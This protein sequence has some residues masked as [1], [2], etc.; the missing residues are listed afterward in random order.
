MSDL[1]PLHS[2][3][4]TRSPVYYGWIILF[5]GTLGTVMTT[6]GQTIG[7]SAFVDRIVEDLALS[8]SQV[9]LAYAVGTLG[10]SLLLPA[11]GRTIDRV[12]PRQAMTAI[13]AL[14]TLA[15]VG[16]GSVRGLGTLAI[17]FLTIRTFGQGSLSLASLHAVNLWFVRRRGLAVGIAGLGFAI[18]NA[19]FPT[20]IEWA[21][22][23]YGWRLAYALL[24]GVVA[25]TIL[26]VA[27]LLVRGRPELYGLEPDGNRPATDRVPLQ[28]RHYTAAEA[29]RTLTFWLYVTADFLVAAFVTG[30]I[31]HHFSLM[32]AAG[33]LE[34]A[35]AV[36]AFV[37]IGLVTAGANF[38]AGFAFDRVEPRFL[39]SGMLGLLCVALALATLVNSPALLW[40]YGAIL[41]AM[42]GVK[43]VLSSGIYGHYFGRLHLGAIAGLATTIS[44][45]G[46]A[47]GPWLFAAGRD[48]ADSY[49]PV[50]WL[51]VVPPLAIALIAPWLRPL[52]ADGQVR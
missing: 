21:I 18:G 43:G 19:L 35:I 8:R 16:M 42:M 38:G 48:L 44:V 45:A 17:G 37:P 24:G 46:T 13:A 25:L 49:A 11:I 33:G 3:L 15:C 40:T 36:K 26:P 52:T 27:A 10:G 2:P 5:A 30:L 31:F 32:A 12:G 20:A 39:L 51:S 7:V 50:L 41:G 28:E 34:R 29:R 6:P 47:F 14:L 1:P 4:V 23:S 9:S 22:A